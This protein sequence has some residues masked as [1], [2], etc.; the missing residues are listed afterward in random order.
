MAQR[1]CDRGRGGGVGRGEGGGRRGE[2]RGGCGRG[3]RGDDRPNFK[4]KVKACMRCGIAA[5]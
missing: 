2:G 1:W 3:G 5:Y 4:R